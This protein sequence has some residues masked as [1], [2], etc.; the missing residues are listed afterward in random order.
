VAQAK[1]KKVS[2]QV[3]IR[4][5]NKTTPELRTDVARA[6]SWVEVDPDDNDAWQFLWTAQRRLSWYESATWRLEN[7]EPGEDIPPDILDAWIGEEQGI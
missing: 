2:R 5:L 3:L 7:L 6:K 1:T 4:S